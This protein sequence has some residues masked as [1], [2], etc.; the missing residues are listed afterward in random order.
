MEKK[1][2]EDSLVSSIASPNL[3]EIAI[4]I[5]ELTLD[6][7][8]E[9]GIVKDIPIIGAIAKF[10]SLGITIR[11]RIFEIKILKFLKGLEDIPIE[12]REAFVKKISGSK[13]F[14]RK[15]GQHLLVVLE[16]IDDLDKPALLSKIFAAFVNEEISYDFFRRLSFVVDKLFLPDLEWLH[17]YHESPRY[18]EDI[19]I[20]L[21]NLGLVFLSVLDGG[22]AFTESLYAGNLRDKG[23]SATN[24]GNSS[25]KFSITPL[26]EKFLEIV[27]KYESK[28]G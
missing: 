18:D 1:D 4:D 20:S 8:L 17:L 7:F 21:S 19:S 11:D 12:K 23:L 26:G 27:S 15:V 9:D 28:N 22:N 2:L 16:R 14:E 5:G 25:S 3:K 6:S 10:Y 24:P 13:K